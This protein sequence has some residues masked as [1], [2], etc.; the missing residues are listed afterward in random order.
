MSDGA[1]TP[2][3]RPSARPAGAES[4]S[5]RPARSTSRRSTRR[6][7]SAE[8][9]GAAWLPDVVTTLLA[10][11]LAL[12]VGAV[13]IAFS[14]DDAVE[15]LG[16][17]FSYPPD[18]F[19][20]SPARRSGRR[21][22]RWS[23]GSVGSLDA[24]GTTLVRAAP[25]ICAGLG[26]TLAFRAGLFNIGAQGQLDR[27]RAAAPATSAS[28]G[29]CRPASTCSRRCSPACSAARSGAASPAS[30]RPAPAPTR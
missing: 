18:F 17:V 12:V 30:S 27:R 13:L 9:P 6:S 20:R 7:P 1:S 23:T 15:S 4:P 19:S 10:I 29:T 5:R 3:T 21:T 2:P 11:V 28:P 26:V 16:Y 8:P 14:D 22:P 24:I 25:L